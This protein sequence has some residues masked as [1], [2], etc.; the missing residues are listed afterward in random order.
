MIRDYQAIG[1]TWFLKG[2]QRLIP[3]SGQH[4]GVKLISTLHYETGE[5]LC[6]EEESYDA[7]AFL[8]FLHTV[9][10]HYPTGWIVLAVRTFLRY[11][12]EHP[13]EVINQLCVRI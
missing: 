5:I 8:R 1:P 3:T 6:V 9:L 11:V 10:A 2:K 7:E 12:D 4:K 13:D